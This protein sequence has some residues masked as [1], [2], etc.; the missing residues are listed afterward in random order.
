[1]FMNDLHYDVVV[2]GAGPS[3][4]TTA[5]FAARN[6][7]RTLIIEKRQEI[8]SPVRCGE[9][10]SRFWL[11]EVEL[12]LDK[13]WYA[14]QVKGARVISPSKHTLV[15][16]EKRAGNEVG[17]V[18][19]RDKFDKGLAALAVKEG[20]E[21]ML[22][23][24]AID[25]LKENGYVKG[26]KARH[27]G[28]TFNIYAKIVVAADGYESQIGRWA[29][30]DTKL[31]ANDIIS[32]FQYRLTNIELNPDFCDFY[33]GRCY[34][35]GGY[36]WVFP[37]DE[38]TA[39]VGIGIQLKQLKEKGEPKKVLDK[40][41][42]STK[43]FAKGQP[44]E[45]VAGAVS[46]SQPLE[47]TVDNGIMLVGDA[48][49]MIDPV[50]G[51]GIA[52][53]CRAGKVCGIVAAESIQSKDYSSEFLQKYEQGWRKLLEE[54][55]YRNWLVKE[56]LVTLSDETIDMMIQTAIEIGVEHLSTKSILDAIKKKHPELVK[57][58]EEFL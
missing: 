25:V 10:I 28:E 45:E 23:T 6:G 15:I 41:I 13:K 48:A 8:G 33:L 51:G 24:T 7:A 19:E 34:A 3:G 1:M 11:D 46:I 29:G 52:N 35:P 16:D 17:F 32:C 18:L 57:E 12:S 5:R 31:K 50:T 44:L 22:K 49:R 30:F 54:Q 39:N 4:S 9:G 42:K 21:I 36:I 38:E 27:W 37:K 20:A 26:V 55:L 2:V 56:K 40:W 47:K 14:W 43:E 53:G 58:F